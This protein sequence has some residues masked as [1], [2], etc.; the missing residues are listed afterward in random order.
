M[1]TPSIQQFQET[2]LAVWNEKDR[3]KRD[4]MMTDIYADNIIMYD[5]DF[6]LNGNAAISDFIDKVQADPVFDFKATQQIE[7][8]QNGARLFWSINTG[9]GLLTGMDFILLVAGKAASI[10]VFMNPVS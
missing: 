7:T 9:K 2:H 10:H 5:P 6:I 8:T 1:N 4:R 3:A